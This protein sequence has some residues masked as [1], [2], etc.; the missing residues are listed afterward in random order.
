MGEVPGSASGRG[1]W[2]C[3]VAV[4]T[5]AGHVLR[6]QKQGCSS[7]MGR[8][9]VACALLLLDPPGRP[10]TLRKQDPAGSHGRQSVLDGQ[11]GRRGCVGGFG[12]LLGIRT[13]AMMRPAHSGRD[14][15]GAVVPVAGRTSARSW[16]PVADSTLGWAIGLRNALLVGNRGRQAGLCPANICSRPRL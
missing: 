9:D 1:G 2:R 12:Q 16:P 8:G 11:D 3:A 5:V 15:R 10:W 13:V 6:V 4:P 7:R 14:A